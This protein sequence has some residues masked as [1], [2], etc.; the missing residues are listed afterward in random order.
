VVATR[1]GGSEEIVIE[2]KLGMLVQPKD[3]DGLLRAILEALEAEWDAGYIREYAKR[4]TWE[5][6]A[7][8]I[9]G[10][11]EEVLSK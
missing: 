3:A 5:R 11:Y 4:F 10:V 1:N 7:E 2:D 6:I 9:V 8:R